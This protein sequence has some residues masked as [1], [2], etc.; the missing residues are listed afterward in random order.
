MVLSWVFLFTSYSNAQ[1]IYTT[2]NIV[3]P[4]TTSSG[5]TWTNA[6]Y[7][8][9]LTCW[10][11]GDPGYCGPNAIVRPGDN[12]NFSYGSTYIYQQQNVA[13]LLPNTGTGLQVNGYN[14]RCY[15]N[16]ETEEFDHGSD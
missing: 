5:S 16:I 15:E 7:Q 10:A 14:S 12:I 9:S 1:D 8:N 4:T 11:Y 6:V 3:V 2:G 13:S